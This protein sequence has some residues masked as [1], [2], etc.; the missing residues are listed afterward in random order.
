MSAITPE[1][2]VRVSENEYE[3]LRMKKN[4]GAELIDNIRLVLQNEDINFTGD[5]SNSFEL[6][7]MR[8]NAWVA[9]TNKYAGLVDRG[10]NPGTT[11]N[12]DALKDWVR[13]KLGITDEPE[14]TN[15]TWKIIRKIAAAG[16]PPKRYAKKA[17]K[18]VIYDHGVPNIKRQTGS[19]RNK[20]GKFAKKVKSIS[21][22]INRIIKKINRNINKG[23]RKSI[24]T[25]SKTGKYY[26]K[27]RKYK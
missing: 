22:K 9:S 24:K 16:I 25:L 26:N 7:L 19:K 4:I 1:P 23:I 3:R 20:S 27:L 6:F 18:M 11:V 2:L 14:L 17:I 21:K 10:L 15:V 12:F 8:D 13:I 5:L